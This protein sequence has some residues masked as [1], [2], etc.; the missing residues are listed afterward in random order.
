MERCERVLCVLCVCGE[1]V[2]ERKGEEGRGRRE[3][4]GWEGKEGGG[5]NRRVRRW[6]GGKVS[7]G[8]GGGSCGGADD[9]ERAYVNP[10]PCLSRSSNS[11]HWLAVPPIC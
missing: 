2:G 1:G 10:D 6:E 8:L 5:K 11:E 9:G 3:E 4:K 7:K